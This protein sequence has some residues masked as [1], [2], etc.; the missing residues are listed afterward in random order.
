MSRSKR[1]PKVGCDK[2]GAATV[3]ARQDFQLGSRPLEPARYAGAIDNKPTA[4]TA[5]IPPSKKQAEPV[6]RCG[7]VDD[8]RPGKALAV[9]FA[10]TSAS[11]KFSETAEA[12]GW[13]GTGQLIGAAAGSAVSNRMK[14]RE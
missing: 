10:M 13:I 8:D 2:L 12:Y 6:S 11:V 7:G 3:I 4:N 9:M 14:V 1:G 5:G